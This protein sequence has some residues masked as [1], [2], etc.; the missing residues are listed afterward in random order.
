MDQLK[1]EIAGATKTMTAVPKPLKFL[2]PK[3]AEIKAAY[4]AQ[5]DVALKV[6]SIFLL[7]LLVCS[8]HL[9]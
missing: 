4:E 2:F 3:Y 6:S 1:V 5:T 8:E 7:K 9:T